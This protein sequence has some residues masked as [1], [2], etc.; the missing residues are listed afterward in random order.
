MKGVTTTKA[1]LCCLLAS[2]ADAAT[3]IG[4]IAGQFETTTTGGAAYGIPIQVAAGMNGLKP[5]VALQYNSQSGDGIAGH[6]WTLSGFSEISRCGLT[7]AL[8][9]RVQGVRFSSADRFCLDG[10]PLLLLSG[11]HGRDG[12]VYRR[13]IHTHE[14]VIARGAQASGPAWFEM[15]LPDGSAHRFG[16]D[17]DSRVEA[18]G[19]SEVRTWAINE[20][21][22]RFQQRV[23]FA[24]SE[25]SVNGEHAPAEI[26]W[27][28]GP[29]ETFEQARYRLVFEHAARPPGDRRSGFL[30]GT[31]WRATQRLATIRY[32]YLDVTGLREVHS[33]RLDYAAADE[34]AD[35]R[36]RLA[37]VTQCGPSECLAPT[38][39][40]WDEGP[41]QRGEQ[42][43]ATLPTNKYLFF[44]DFNG[45]GA[46]DAFGEKDNRWSVWPIVPGSGAFVAPI[47]L[48]G[49]VDQT[50][51]TLPIDYNGD[52]RTDLLVSSLASDNLL[53]YQAPTTSG[54]SVSTRNTGVARAR[55]G[56]LA[57]MDIDGDGLDDF[58][59]VN[60]GR[61]QVQTNTGN[62]LAAARDAGVPGTV[63]NEALHA[64]DFDGDG[65]EDLLVA[66]TGPAPRTLTWKAYLSEGTTF[67]TTAV[68]TF[69]HELQKRLLKGDV[70]GDGLTDIIREQ[71]GRWQTILS[72]GT[73]SAAG[74]GLI[75][76]DCTDP[77]THDMFANSQ[78]IDL[79]GDG[80]VELLTAFDGFR[81]LRSVNDCFA[82]DNVVQDYAD[83]KERGFGI[84]G[85][86]DIDGDGLAE[87]AF[88]ND[89][90]QQVLFAG[91]A[92]RLRPDG[93]TPS[94]R[95][96][97]V[98]RITDGL[99]N[100]HEIVYS[101][102]TAWAGYST[103]GGDLSGTRLIRGGGHVVVRQV[104]TN[105]ASGSDLH[106]VGY[107][108]T[109]ARLSRTGRGALGFE[110]IRSTDSRDG[111]T[112]DTRYLQVHPYI[113]RVDLITVSRA[114]QTL[115]RLDPTWS[116]ATAYAS[117]EAFR[118]V[119]FVYLSRESRDE[120]EAD[121]DG[122]M[123]GALIRTT[124]RTL[125]W[126]TAHGAMVNDQVVVTAPQDGNRS[127]RS[128]TTVTLDE[129]IAA[130]S[131]CLAL[132]ARVD[133][134]RDVSG[135]GAITRT[136]QFS[137]DAA[138]CRLAARTEGPPATPALQRRMSWNWDM[139][140]RTTSITVRDVAGT[141]APRETRFRYEESPF[142]ASAEEQIISG[143]P[144]LVTRRSWD[145][146]LGLPAATT[147]P[148]GNTTT[149]YRDEFGRVGAE[150]RPRGSTLVNYTACGPCFAPN[151]RYA[152]LSTRSD[153]YWSETQH[154]S[155]GRVVGS[156][157]VLA[158]GRATRQVTQYDSLGRVARRSTPHLDDSAP[159]FWTALTYDAIGRP[160]SITQPASETAPQGAVSLVSYAG[161]DTVVRDAELRT[162]TY[163]HDAAGRV[164]SVI[165]PLGSGATYAY[166][167]LGQLVRITDAAGHSRQYTWDAQG[168][169]A[170]S[171]DPDA[172]RRSYTYN[173]YGELIAHS[174]GKS[175]ANIVTLAYDQLGRMLH[176]TEPEGTTTWRYAATPGSSRGLLLTVT[177]PTAASATGFSES[178]VYGPVSRIRQ[179]TTAIDGA[180]YTTDLTYD[181]EGKVL[182]M[183]YPTTVGWRPKFVMSYS[184]GHLTGIAQETP[185]LSPVYTLL[186]MDAHGRDSAARLGAG[187]VEERSS[188][189]AATGRL[190]SIRAGLPPAEANVQDLAYQWDKAGNL[191]ERRDLRASPQLTE[192]F[193]YDAVNRLT[194]V[195]LN[196]AAVLDMRYA[197]DGNIL[198]KSDAGSFAYGTAA[199]RPH[200]VATVSGGPRPATSYSYDANGNMTAGAGRSLGW[201]SFNLP[202]QITQ[203]SDY[204]RFSYG[205]G[206]SR[207]R[208]DVKA[209]AVTKTIHYVGPHFE[210]EIEG[211]TRRFRSNVFA[212]GRAV[213][214]QVESSPN[215]LAANYLLYDHAGSVDQRV[216][217]V[218]VGADRQGQSFDAWGK[219]RN[220]NW[221]ADATDQ[222][223]ADQHFTE[224]GYTG[225]EHLDN[226]RLI[227]MNGRLDDP[228]LGRMISPDPM[229]S[230]LLNPEG[231]N[232]YSYVANNPASYTDP[233]GYFLKRIGKFVKRLVSRIGDFGRRIGKRWGREILAVVGSY[234]ANRGASAL[235]D[236][237]GLTE[238]VGFS[239]GA[240]LY[241]DSGDI[242]VGSTLTAD[243]PASVLIGSL[244]GG[245]VAGGISSGSLKGAGVGA[246]TGGIS[247]GVGAYYGG[248]YAAGRVLTEAYL[249]GGTSAAQ[250]GDFGR[251]ATIRGGV[252]A[253]TWAAEVMRERMIKQ[254]RIGF[255][256]PT[257]GLLSDPTA[258][259]R[260]VSV[261]FRGDLFKLGGCRYPCRN[262][263][264]GGVQGSSGNV[265]GFEYEPGSIIDRVV[266]AY[267]GPHDFLNSP[268]FYDS[269][270]NNAS[271]P[272]ILEV[273]NGAH[274]AVA[275]PFVLSSVIPAY[276]YGALGD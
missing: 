261:G 230:N 195:R 177:G 268:F 238:S 32:R 94:L 233:S 167:A 57:V 153:G 270:G 112:T 87:V 209:G 193:S 38:V 14:R 20:I 26:R 169:L 178:Y 204:A 173:A 156:A 211:A 75:E 229:L 122:G 121:S 138:S 271:R 179:T 257:E 149:W 44:A 245:A 82:F 88:A 53:V 141:L 4:R 260:G 90:T 170:Q 140:G 2:A 212:Y 182:T 116:V 131:G 136:T 89:S 126:N 36:S 108:Y 47:T 1:L 6:G 22:D 217:A 243:V 158:D 180:S 127:H 222:R 174:D 263:P 203:G 101:V 200:A 254:S 102:L 206:R 120:Y 52:G 215:G 68:G 46:T 65:R 12:A 139:A 13:E 76:L 147:N 24:Y 130:A 27:T 234:A 207:V 70:N 186:A 183:T 29:G 34:S 208:Q 150:F 39:V 190:R 224:R 213:M 144:D 59:Y 61:V 78:P 111:L 187:A 267:A 97:L 49:A 237:A 114:G 168:Q 184:L 81:I 21:E 214:S 128:V 40:D 172:G 255:H 226:V 171:T 145:D 225:H 246:L 133:V 142:R 119:V 117:G 269:A 223:Y 28:Y 123:R 148:Q 110:T 258:N 159:T 96:D 25:D 10:Q 151:A 157:S 249:G 86:S 154:D 37:A 132:P 73:S 259:S 240:P 42:I 236:R 72:R 105:S 219:R 41:G 43:V 250:G 274:V 67:A 66:Y 54:G 202:S 62:G 175:P 71:N 15:R 244:V 11:V 247:S 256:H 109:N 124:T 129:T 5:D 103:I 106:T 31:P 91:S 189:D 194:Q 253:L 241:D 95:N 143:E 216:R 107:S 48:G 251:G 3:T 276:S 227:H 74:P 135:A 84:R 93:E 252:G 273:I 191:V 16:N 176:R 188:H 8:D 165:A 199:T 266:E 19:T 69:D 242:M 201:T 7:R 92:P 45:D 210:V 218:G 115:S 231:L 113:G 235:A 50:L 9:G 248:S 164:L 118:S 30:W 239:L 163:R 79:D 160:K 77:R 196:G 272:D 166:D 18:A 220:T 152:V 228:L 98:R 104:R 134:T 197:P 262:S 161:L 35:P 198:S 33:W 80:R 185:A 56:S 60:A 275:T 63:L 83:L 137:W 17:A 155:F 146:A 64:G 55:L 265:F 51:G 192:A 85:V 99:G 162:S 125:T 264:L 232:P 221:T 58:V 23:G 205:P 181:A 100:W